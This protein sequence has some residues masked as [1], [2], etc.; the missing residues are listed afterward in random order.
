MPVLTPGTPFVSAD[1]VITVE[2][3]E[4]GTHRFRLEVEDDAGNRSARDER[5][6]VVRAQA[7]VI[8]DIRRRFGV[9]GDEV[10]IVGRGFDPDAARNQVTFS[11]GVATPVLAASATELRVHVPQPA[12]TGP[13]TVSTAIGEARSPFSFVIP[14]TFAL[15]IG[16]LNPV[17]IAH[18]PRRNELWVSHSV[19]I[20]GAGTA[21]ALSVIDLRTHGLAATI[22]AELGPRET[23]ATVAAE[24][25]LAAL[26]NGE[27]SSTTIVDAVAR[28]VRAHVKVRPL[29]NG[30]AFRPDD[31]RFAYVVCQGSA[32]AEPGG[33]DVIDTRDTPRVV[34]RIELGRLPQRVVF[35]PDAKFAFVNEAGDGTVAVIDAQVHRLLRRVKV[36]REATSRPTDVAVAP[37]STFPLLAANAGNGTASVV[38]D[39]LNVKDIDLGPPVSA[40]A[41][42]PEGRRGWLAGSGE[43]VV[44]AV[45][46]AS[47]VP[48]KFGVGAPA[49]GPK[50]VVMHVEGR[51]VFVAHPDDSSVTVFDAKGALR[52]VVPVADGPT[53]GVCTQDGTLVCFACTKAGVVIAIDVASVL[54]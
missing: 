28:Q 41:V 1:P 52:A 35:S 2:G 36:G 20:T 46:L 7:P 15:K 13:V 16:G 9:W 23:A 29:P 22:P 49:N 14:V 30:V 33:V 11:N 51:G 40:A 24:R 43:R 45:E 17:D 10:A 8:D 50:S 6:V 19:A 32:A 44:F 27:S 47:A 54:G 5:T 34:A 12:V 48:T 42:D 3:L 31:G 26:T 4:P 38:D 39:A 37:R 21:G 53:R 25:P 18:E